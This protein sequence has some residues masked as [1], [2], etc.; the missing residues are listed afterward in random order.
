MGASTYVLSCGVD[1]LAPQEAPS[2]YAPVLGHDKS[3]NSTLREYCRG[4]Y[5]TFTAL[6]HKC[7]W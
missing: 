6:K 1:Q 5:P 7:K 3:M 2:T 4:Q